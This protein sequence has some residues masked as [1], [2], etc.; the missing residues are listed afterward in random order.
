MKRLARWILATAS[1]LSAGSAS[2]A[3]C[4]SLSTAPSSNAILGFE[5]PLAW[6]AKSSTSSMIMVSATN[7]RTQGS[8]AY[9][10][11][12]PGNLVTLTSAPVASTASA[13][14][15]L[16]DAG[17]SFAVDV[18]LPAQV[19]NSN[20][21]GQM[22]MYVN[23]PSRGLSKVLIGTVYF[24]GFRP[25]IYN[26]L[27]YPIPS[28]VGTALGG[29]SFTDLTFILMV[30]SPGKLTGPYLFDN[31]RVHSV[32]LVTTD[33]NTKPPA[34][35]GGSV[36]FVVF[37]G[38]PVA[39]AFDIG[40]VQV[41]NG[42]HLKLGTAGSTTVQLQ[43]GFEGT[44]SFTCTYIPDS[45]DAT[46]KSYVLESCTGGMQA[47]DLVGA[48]WA[49]LNIVGGD[50]TMKIR[51]QLAKNPVGDTTGTG[52]IP[53]M[54][55]FWGDTGGCVPTV[56]ANGTN[57]PVALN[58]SASCAAQTGQASQIV[59]GYFNTANS[60]QFPP[61]WIVTPTPEFARRQ[62]NGSPQNNLGPPPPPPANDPDFPFDQE[63]HLNQGGDFDA[64]YRVNG[65]LSAGSTAD[66][67]YKA[68]FDGS[69]SAHAVL[70]GN[71][72][73]VL[74]VE[75]K[76][77]SDSGQVSP[78]GPF[79]NPLDTGNL[80]AYLFGL[81]LDLGG[82]GC[83]DATNCSFSILDQHY[84]LP[85][86]DIWIFVITLGATAKVSI[87]TSA[88]LTSSEVNL[89]FGPD[90]T[91]GAH[92]FGGVGVPGADGGVDVTVDLLEVATPISADASWSISTAPTQCSATL[93]TSLIGTATLSSGGGEVDLEATLGFCP[94]CKD[95]SF[96]LFGWDPLFQYGTG[97]F[98]FDPISAT[99][100][101]PDPSLT[102]NPPLNV[103][104]ALPAA[105]LSGIGFN[106]SATASAGNLNVPCNDS[107][108]V[109]WAWQSS[110][111]G[112]SLPTGCMG[113]AT[114]NS[115]GQHVITL[116][117]TDKVQDQFSTPISLTG[118][119]SQTVT[120]GS[121]TPGPHITGIDCMPAG[122]GQPC[123]QAAFNLSPD[124][125]VDSGITSMLF[126]GTVSGLASGTTATTT[127]T[128][129]D[130]TNTVVA[131][132]STSNT[133]TS[134]T[135]TFTWST[136]PNLIS[137]QVANYTV[138]MATTVGG[139][140]FGTAATITVTLENPPH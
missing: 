86:I 97:L 74:S 9:V 118:T 116:T 79:S 112:D 124:P 61:N 138:M 132:G 30:S 22:Q 47:G 17:A 11:S 57:P 106:L 109:N 133:S 137:G 58:P 64:Y 80:G 56:T 8:F 99:T 93:D 128:V 81:N 36:D 24:G 113:I 114:L 130:S 31:L 13:L 119:Y 110:V 108:A 101:I 76:L 40:V 95:A 96:K 3:L 35:Y 46:G 104:F 21:I 71:D 10:V 136:V 26:T 102:C 89:N 16:G 92:L 105:P 134:P 19:G 107:T 127:W 120:V 7:I 6:N 122:S 37:G 59:T 32:P 139:S 123:P 4:Q 15:G 14:A 62:G 41:P 75:A 38:T 34:G 20:N 103:S 77:D 88:T 2:Q 67:H 84:D 33:A 53:A 87:D 140:A 135:S 45:T 78:T 82:G 70:F 29:A 111:A 85:P 60:N 23:S 66:N 5:T 72:V 49:N 48:D 131:T 25:G 54:P 63:G 94:L 129:M 91:I 44:P 42:F 27:S 125:I 69:L 126:T 43:L 73:N 83:S 1:V 68:S 100:E 55:T 121:P 51:A 115:T 12:N 39:Q 50:P 65:D 90:V 28:A 98:E 117:V 52:I 18:L